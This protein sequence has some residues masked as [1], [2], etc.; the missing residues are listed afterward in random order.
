MGSPACLSQVMSVGAVYDANIGT[1]CRPTAADVIAC[2]SD[3]DPTLDLLAPG[4]NISTT[5]RGG[6]ATGG[7]RG[8]SFA[9]PHAAGAAA[10]LIGIEPGLT[11]NAIEMLLEGTGKR[12]VDPRNGVTAARVDLYAAV[13]YL[14][15]PIPAR[16]RGVRR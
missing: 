10:V 9:S 13:Q 7:S 5:R 16:R 1:E 8:T 4:A 2:F 12:L 6:G 15:L 14:L 3:S 11:A